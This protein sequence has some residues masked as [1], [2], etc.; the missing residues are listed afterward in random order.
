MKK[1]VSICMI[2]KNEDSNLKRC[3]D[4]LLPIIHEKWS[5]LIIVDTGST[6]ETVK[7][8]KEY[9][10]NVFIKKFI[11]WNFSKARNFGISK[12]VGEKILVVDADEELKQESLYILEDTICNPKLTQPTTF[13]KLLNFYTRDRQ[14][15]TETVQSRLFINDGFHYEG[16]PHNKPIVKAPYLFATNIIFNHFGYMFEGKE[17]LAVKKRKR[18]LPPL[19]RQYKKNPHDL[20]VS[21]HLIKTYNLIGEHKKIIAMGDQWIKDLD[22]IHYHEGWTAY[23]EVFIYLVGAYLLSDDIENAERI[24]KISQKYSNKLLSIDI[25]IGNHY[26][27]TNPKKTRKYFEQ[28][29]IKSTE[30]GTLYERLLTSNVNIVIPEVLNFLAIT[31]FEEGNYERAGECII[32][33]VVLNN[34]RLPIRWDIFNEK[35]CK[36]RLI[37]NGS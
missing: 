10:R 31:Y 3:L 20:H 14:Q 16:S 5:E 27:P 4:S 33:G 8:A 6:D 7:V 35:E 23:L 11:P 21:T 12:A 9:T 15:F 29:I 19:E 2:V 37:Q 34:N 13:I 18:S 25:A 22:K 32:D 26:A 17:D 28:A 30:E 1:K 36:K 24:S